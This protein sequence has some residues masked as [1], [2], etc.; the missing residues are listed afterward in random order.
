MEYYTH[1]SDPEY[2]DTHR[3]SANCGSYA[4][5]IKEWYDADSGFCDDVGDIFDWVKEMVYEGYSDEEISDIYAEGII[6]K[7]LNDFVGEIREVRDESSP[8]ESNEELV[9]L[10]TFCYYDDDGWSDFDFHFKV[11]R[12]GCWMEKCGNGEVRFCT[13]DDWANGS[14]AYISK[15]IFFAH[16]AA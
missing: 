13:L 7:I 16:K 15:T 1:N 6:P 14:L 9:A 10:R 8:L 5:N 11:L 3:S 12:D 2:Y 4:F